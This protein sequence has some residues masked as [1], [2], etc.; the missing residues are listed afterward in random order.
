VGR[1]ASGRRG[2][3]DDD[4]RTREVG[5]RHSSCEAGEQSGAAHC[6]GI[7]LI[8]APT[9]PA[10]F[11]GHCASSSSRTITLHYHSHHVGTTCVRM[12]LSFD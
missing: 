3:E 2:A 1:S 12:G 5:P 11:A 10:A 9:S 4:A 7:A 6:G 8:I